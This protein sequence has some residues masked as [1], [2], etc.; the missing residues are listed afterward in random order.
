MWR[1]GGGDGGWEMRAR[2]CCT[3]GRAFAGLFLVP[4]SRRDRLSLMLGNQ[5]PDAKRR[6]NKHQRWTCK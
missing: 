4:A 6:K 3:R 2:T 1:E 5:A